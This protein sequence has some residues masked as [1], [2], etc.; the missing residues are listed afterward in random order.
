MLRHKKL[1]HSKP[2]DESQVH[3]KPEDESQSELSDTDTSLMGEESE[4]EARSS[5]SECDAWDSI[6]VLAFDKLKSQ[7][8]EDVKTLMQKDNLE[9]A[10]ARNKV[11]EDMKSAY[12][13]AV[14]NNFMARMEWFCA[15]QQDPIY[16]AIKQ[17]A[18]SLIDIDFFDRSEAWKYAISKRKYL[19]DNILSEYDPP[20]VTKDEE[21]E[22]EQDDV[23]L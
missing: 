17:T 4:S 8:E 18:A 15:I 16:K 6:I 20:D 21:S 9:E 14:M 12:R 10:D 5:M 3:S 11:Y 23:M 2:E 22:S 13:K 19:F 7:F 1:V